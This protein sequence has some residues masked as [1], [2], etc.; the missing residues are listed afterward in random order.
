VRL[1]ITARQDSQWRGL[2]LGLIVLVVVSVV[3]PLLADLTARPLAVFALPTLLTAVISGW[4]PTAVISALSLSVATLIG[5]LGSL[6][7]AALGARLTVIFLAC[8]AGVVGAWFREQQEAQMLELAESNLL[9]RTLERAMVP[10]TEPGSEFEVAT[11]YVAAERHLHI[12]GD[13]L[14]A[15]RLADGSLAV[16]VGDVCGH[17][18]DEAALGVAFRSAWRAIV[19]T[20]P[21]DPVEWIEQLNRMFVGTPAA[22]GDSYVT[23]CTGTINHRTREAT[24]V[25]AGHPWPISVGADVQIA[26]MASGAPIGLGPPGWSATTLDV[27]DHT[28]VL[29]TDGLIENPLAHGRQRWG[30]DGLVGW[31]ADT[32]AGTTSRHLVDLLVNEATAG[33]DLRDDAAVMVVRCRSTTTPVSRASRQ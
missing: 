33:R 17:G 27:A 14:D 19:L 16:I 5:A 28:L 8:A 30:E 22:R 12:G 24:L 15:V 25:S 23:A 4:R 2:S 31:L 13:F 3:Y 26:T 9:L 6:S 20:H 1:G 7:G 21:A 11:R 18:P 10:A 29:Y 32:P